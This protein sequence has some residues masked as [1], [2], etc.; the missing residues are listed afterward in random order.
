V[1]FSVFLLLCAMKAFLLILILFQI[2]SCIDRKKERP[3]FATGDQAETA[4]DNHLKYYKT[5]GDIPVPAGFNRTKEPPGSFGEYLRKLP[6]KKDKTVYLWNGEMKRNQSAQF[7][8]IDIPTGNKDLQQCADV[9]MRIRAEYL[10]NQERYTEIVFTDFAGK[11]Y[12]WT[13]SGNRQK[14]GQYL[15]NV[16]GWCGSASLEKHLKPVIDISEICVG[17]VFIKG[18]FP[19]HA[20]IVVDVATNED[21]K[22]IYMLV[23]GYQ[24]AQ[25]IHLL[26][27]PISNTVSPWYQ[28]PDFDTVYTPEWR[29]SCNQLR[30]W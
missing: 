8:V 3:H 13:G 29:F 19:G 14:F 1:E 26:I 2:S 27:N 15:E 21:G 10:F 11:K 12:P 24:P 16:F 22:I 28:I 23:Q 9:V 7:A 17:D 20:V 30:R 5:I 4:N 25:D 18:G 6:L